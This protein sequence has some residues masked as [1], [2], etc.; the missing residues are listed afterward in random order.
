MK[1]E[2]IEKLSSD[3]LVEV[4]IGRLV[5]GGQ[6]LLVTVRRLA[7]QVTGIPGLVDSLRQASAAARRYRHANLV[8]HLGLTEVGDSLCWVSERPFGF[9]LA[10]VFKR[11]SSRE[12]HLAP[13]RALRMGLDLLAGL[14]VL[15]EHGEIHGGLDP[16]D[17][18]VGYDGATRLDAAGLA[19]TLLSA[20]ELKQKSRRGHAAHLAPEVVQGRDPTVQSDVYTAA[21]ILYHLLTGT[22]PVETDEQGGAG[23]SVRHSAVQPPSKLD[24][25]LPYSCDA[26]FI[27]ALGS[28]AGSRHESVA[29]LNNAVGR[30]RAAM[31][32]GPDEGEAGVA[33]FVRGLFPNEALV[34]GQPG[35]LE[36]PAVADGV[37]VEGLVLPADEMEV[38]EDEDTPPDG[39]MQIDEDTPPDGTVPARVAEASAAGS[40]AS[41]PTPPPMPAEKQAPPAPRQAA[42]ASQPGGADEDALARIRAWESMHGGTGEQESGSGSAGKPPPLGR[43]RTP[44][45]P[46][47]PPV[48][49]RRNDPASGGQDGRAQAGTTDDA[50]SVVVDWNLLSDPPAPAQ[51]PAQVETVRDGKPLDAPEQ[52]PGTPDRSIE[53]AK[54]PIVDRETLKSL[55]QP[56]PAA[57]KQ[58][59]QD[60]S[61][62]EAK[63]GATASSMPEKD[64]PGGA[65]EVQDAPAADGATRPDWRQVEVPAAGR[66]FW[67]R[68]VVMFLVGVLVTAAA[69]AVLLLAGVFSPQAP[70][71]EAQAGT[72]TTEVGFLTVRADQPVEV[73]LDGEVLPATAALEHKVVRAGAHR[74]VVSTSGDVELMDEVIEIEPGEKRHVRLVITPRQAPGTSPGEIEG[75]AEDGQGVKQGTRR[76]RPRRKWSR[77]KR[78]TRRVR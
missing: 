6:P 4:I 18:L 39:A 63:A 3:D 10:T 75:G 60:G 7:P 50:S 28:S 49:P 71:D 42:S 20:G 76:K 19:R 17:V 13:L 44:S 59:A 47:P 9:D 22:A 1:L 8:R 58:P 65:E 2:P 29:S 74:L 33:E 37:E 69:L 35:T 68:P 38:G 11:M 34:T 12:V 78:R 32:K 67:Q 14:G 5:N 16:L 41:N 54:T 45:K 46:G 36:R 30:L 70:A 24:R 51:E 27:K 61:P 48:P 26:V 25:S 40:A 53:K 64:A 56:T 62:G 77:R 21:A 43:G 23:I 73:V 55:N 31:L 66:P 52:R 15:H 72:A 57:Y